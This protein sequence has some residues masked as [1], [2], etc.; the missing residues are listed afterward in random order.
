MYTT[1]NFQIQRDLDKNVQFEV[2]Y[3]DLLI[4]KNSR[5]IS[6]VVLY[7]P[8]NFDTK[9]IMGNSIPFKSP[10]YLTNILTMFDQNKQYVIVYDFPKNGRLFSLFNNT[11]P[12]FLNVKIY[13]E[14]D[15]DNEEL[16]LFD[17]E[18]S[19]ILFFT[20]K[21]QYIPNYPNIADYKYKTYTKF[22]FGDDR[23]FKFA[24]VSFYDDTKIIP[25][26]DKSMFIGS[27]ASDDYN[28][29]LKQTSKLMPFMKRIFVLQYNKTNEL[30]N[31]N[32]R[33]F[34]N[35]Q[36]IQN[37]LLKLHDKINTYQDSVLFDNQNIID[38]IYSIQEIDVIVKRENDEIKGRCSRVY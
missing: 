7:S 31:T 3:N 15:F 11:I 35:Y 16:N 30:I 13:Y 23:N 36:N 2:D 9:N 18:F 29:F 4:G 25:L 20:Q 26:I 10:F 8:K 34:L 12:S 17:S 1:P 28:E 38:L 22:A 5:S 37:E 6:D 32:G 27:I 33:C 14:D 19:E 21:E 24:K